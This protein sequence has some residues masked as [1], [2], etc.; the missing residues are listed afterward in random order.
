MMGPVMTR[1][2]L[3]VLLV[4]L[5]LSALAKPVDCTDKPECWPEGSAMQMGLLLNQ[6][7]EKADKQMAAKHA[8]LVSLVV[9]SSSHATPVDERLI[10]ALTSQ[11][12]AWAL[13]RHE[14]CELIGSLTG[15]GG[16]WPSTWAEQC[17]VNH[18]EL[19]LRRIRSA[20]ACIQK[21]PQNQRFSEQNRCLQQL[22]P[23]TN[24]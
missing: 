9:A 17:V 22:A 5:P 21:I 23:L 3:L 1:Y 4:A 11:Q 20:I 24:R 16:R 15:A 10:K 8:E 2:Y 14:E 19:R 18:T 13:Y 12:A 7:L 6:K